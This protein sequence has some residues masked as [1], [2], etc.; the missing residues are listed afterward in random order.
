M[1]IVINAL[2]ILVVFFVLLIITLFAIGVLKVNVRVNKGDVLEE[3]KGKKLAVKAEGR[4]IT[5]E[6]EEEGK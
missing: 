1:E 2:A 6:L 4:E 5:R 3:M